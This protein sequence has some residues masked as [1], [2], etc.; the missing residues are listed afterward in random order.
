MKS[1]SD[2]CQ[3]KRCGG[4]GLRKFQDMNLALLAKQYWMILQKEDKACVHIMLSKYCHSTDAWDVEKHGGDLRGW[5]GLLATRLICHDGA[6]FLIGNGDIEMWDRPWIPR[7]SIEEIKLSF[8]YNRR[9]AFW[10]VSDLFL[11]GT[12]AWNEDIIR[13]CF[14]EEVARSILQIRPLIETNDVLFWKSSNSGK[15]SVKSA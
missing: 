11:D 8:K 13:A 10:K 14:E 12:K 2:I 6:G 9:H 7:K 5:Q 3:P 15:F 4:L 1:W